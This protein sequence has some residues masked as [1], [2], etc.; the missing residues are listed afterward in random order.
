MIQQTSRS[1]VSTAT[2]LSY[3]PLAPLVPRCRP[4]HQPSRQ[5][6]TPT[7]FYV[8]RKR[9]ADYKQNPSSPVKRTTTSLKNAT[10]NGIRRIVTRPTETTVTIKASE[11]AH[12]AEKGIITSPLANLIVDRIVTGTTSTVTVDVNRIVSTIGATTIGMTITVAA[13][14]LTTIAMNWANDNPKME[15]RE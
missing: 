14:R 15:E 10:H 3:P 13:A 8:Y 9:S 1:H 5:Q 4:N 7:R 12:V 11:T 2:H 6:K